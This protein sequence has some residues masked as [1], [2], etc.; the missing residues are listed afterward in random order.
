MQ[1]IVEPKQVRIIKY[2]RYDLTSF[3]HNY[4]PETKGEPP[5]E[6][7]LRNLGLSTKQK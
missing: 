5:K 3:I 2:F 4:I 1:I 6:N 7:R